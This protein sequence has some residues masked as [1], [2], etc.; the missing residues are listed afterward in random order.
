[1]KQGDSGTYKNQDRV[2]NPDMVLHC[3]ESC[4][5]RKLRPISVIILSF[6]MCEVDMETS[7]ACSDSP[8]PSCSQR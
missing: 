1:M 3:D 5:T 7:A 2:Q 8:P 6:L 4:I